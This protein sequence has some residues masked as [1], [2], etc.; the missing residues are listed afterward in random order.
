M[1]KKRKLSIW[2]SLVSA[3]TFMLVA[4]PGLCEN[5]KYLEGTY[6]PLLEGQPFKGTTI[7]VASLK[8]WVCFQ[9]AIKKAS[10][11]TKLTG[12]NVKFDLLPIEALHS[13]EV[14]ELSSR[15]GAYD[16]ID[17]PVSWLFPYF[18]YMLPL[19]DLIKRDIG[20]IDK[21]EEELSLA[22]RGTKGDDGCYYFVQ[23]HANAQIGYYRKAL[24]EDPAEKAKFKERYGYEL[25]VPKT[26]QELHDVAEFFTRPPKMYG[27]TM[28]LAGDHGWIAF[29]DFYMRTG[30]N[31]VEKINGKYECTFKRGKGREWAIKIAK[32][33]QDAIYKYKYMN[34][35]SAK[36]YTGGMAEYFF[37]GHA[38][39][40]WG[41]LSDYW[42]YMQT[43]KIK[44][45]IGEVGTFHW[46]S[47]APDPEGGYASYWGIGIARD[48]RHPGAAWE[49][50]KYLL[51]E[52]LQFAMAKEGGQLPPLKQLAY[53]TSI[54]PGG[55][56]PPQ[57]YYAYLKA[58][59]PYRLPILGLKPYRS[60]VELH[61]KLLANQITPEE[62]VDQVA[63]VTE[64]ALQEANLK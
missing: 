59:I 64:T 11:F 10:E 48:S 7:T 26:L 51:S 55:I 50:I 23:H 14:L 21:F 38:A 31:W 53:R 58:R 54:R 37:G 17:A 29:L 34:P 30:K 8:G 57:L 40:A 47:P 36:F 42:G 62:F 4:F 44:E 24:F 5:I 22:Q 19:N 46:P 43:P 61:D 60:A 16:L 9:P 32:W 56:N 1:K 2:L 15:T 33:Q 28:N 63:A 20:S 49:F 39:M 52:D 25:K 12:I 45:K 41:W 3:A 27:V 35:D 18:P 6:P 13:K